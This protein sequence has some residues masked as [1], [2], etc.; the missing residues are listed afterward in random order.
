MD[1]A[2]VPVTLIIDLSSDGKDAFFV[3]YERGD[4]DKSF[5]I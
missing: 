4:R 1:K 5:R 3:V 2:Y